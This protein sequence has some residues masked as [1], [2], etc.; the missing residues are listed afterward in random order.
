MVGTKYSDVAFFVNVRERADFSF[1]D[2]LHSPA[3][4]LGMSST[5]ALVQM[6]CVAHTCESASPNHSR[7]GA[8][9]CCRLLER[10]CKPCC[11][12]P[13][14]VAAQRREMAAETA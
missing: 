8:M 9:P 10:S 6:E 13:A 3:S 12:N 14:H 5:A 11:A 2:G 4:E 7:T 1:D